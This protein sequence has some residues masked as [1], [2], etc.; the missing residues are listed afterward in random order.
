MCFISAEKT[1][2]D[3]CPLGNHTSDQDF[4]KEMLG[5]QVKIFLLKNS[6]I[7]RRTEQ[8]RATK[9]RGSGGGQFF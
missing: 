5:H 9:R 2:I 3:R 8:T 6:S 1:L 7:K 4:A